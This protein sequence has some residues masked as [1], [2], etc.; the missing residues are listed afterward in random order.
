MVLLP[1]A[2]PHRGQAMCHTGRRLSETLST[3]P[4][5]QLHYVHFHH[6]RQH[7]VNVITCHQP[8]KCHPKKALAA[9]TIPSHIYCHLQ[10]I[11]HQ[12]HHRPDDHNPHLTYCHYYNYITIISG[13]II[14]IYCLLS[15]S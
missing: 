14:Y 1:L 12:H 8:S 10:H 9:S 3:L 2:L 5:L 11:Q 15:P 13:N 4:Q 6:H 7:Q